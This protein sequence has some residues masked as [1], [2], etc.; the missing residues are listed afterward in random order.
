MAIKRV[1]AA[2]GL[3]RDVEMKTLAFAHAPEAIP[4]STQLDMIELDEL[5]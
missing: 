5:R 2:V 4:L 3:A 1:D